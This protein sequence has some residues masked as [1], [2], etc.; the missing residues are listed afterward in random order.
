MV[1]GLWVEEVKSIAKKNPDSEVPWYLT[2][3]GAEGRDIQLIIDQG[4][5]QL[6][7]VNSISDVHQGK[8]VAVERNNQAILQLQKRFIGLRIKEVNFSE[9]IRND[10]NF[11]WPQGEDIKCCCAHII[12]LDLNTSLMARQENERI[13]FPVVEWIK[14][15]CT[16]RTPKF[17]KWVL[18]LTLHAQIDW[19]DEISEYMSSFLSE[20][21]GREPV[22][23]NYCKRLFGE[24]LY[25]YLSQGVQTDFKQFNRTDQQKLIMVIVPKMISRL[26][27]NDGW[28]VH[29]Q[30]NLCY[31]SEGHAP[32]ATWIFEFTWNEKFSATPDAIYRSALR[33]IFSAIGTIT[34]Q[35]EIETSS[36]WACS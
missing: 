11:T 28:Q 15:L 29:T 34:Q 2:L 26:V 21:I 10:S 36:I 23:A 33:D 30:N 5:I 7:E 19:S 6:T 32:M 4:L 16:I 3:S 12:N 35:G 13:I 8:I 14:K 27:H 20:N 24:E 22:F 1:R 31:G 17:K 18:C 25:S 9:L